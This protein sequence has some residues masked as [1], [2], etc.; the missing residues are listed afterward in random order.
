MKDDQPAPG[1]EIQSIGW[2]SPAES[3]R[4]ID[5]LVKAGITPEIEVDDGIKKVDVIF[6]SAG[7]K[8]KITV[9]VPIQDVEIACR[10]RDDALGVED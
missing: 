6:G 2:F 10:L 9:F 8:A 3:K 5:A 4:V 1:P 7:L